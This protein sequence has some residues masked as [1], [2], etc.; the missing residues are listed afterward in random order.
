MTFKVRLTQATEADVDRLF[1]FL[2]QHELACDGGDLDLPERA[3]AAWRAGIGTLQPSPFTGRKAGT[4]PFL[5]KLII[6]FGGSGCVALFD[7]ED[8]S[9]VTVVA[10]RHLLEDDYH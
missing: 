4:S 7:I 2:V 1:D 9:T 10:V 6:P 3:I 8:E 5:R